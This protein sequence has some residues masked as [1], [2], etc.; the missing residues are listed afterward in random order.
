MAIPMVVNLVSS[1]GRLFAIEDTAPPDNPFLPARFMLV[2]RNAF[3]GKKLWRRK[4][5]RW[6]AETMYIKTQPLQQQRRMATG[7]PIVT[8]TPGFNSDVIVTEGTNLY[9]HDKALNLELADAE[10]EE[11]HLAASSGFTDGAPQHRTLWSIGVRGISADI[12]V[13]D[14]TKYVEVRGF[15]DF[16]NH[17]YFDPRLNG[18]TLFAGDL[19]I[20]QK[21][22]P[23]AKG[24]WYLNTDFDQYKLWKLNIP[25]T[26]KAIAMA[27]DTVFVAGE[28]MKF[29]NP[30]FENYVAAYA[31]EKG[32]QM[33]AVSA[34]D[35]KKIAE[36]ELQAAPA[37]DGIAAANGKLYV[38]LADGT[39]QCMGK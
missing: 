33:L 14:G 2:A 3:N 9:M 32:G 38:C 35:G 37:W 6:E 29:D 8:K 34:T 10:K 16:H 12:M 26:G 36:Y 19:S 23:K 17:S 13:S 27:G 1:K 21:T 31:G 22:S 30:S 39:I 18:Y 28:P 24:N 20:P 5:T 7:F 25:I 15:P 11:R 4:I